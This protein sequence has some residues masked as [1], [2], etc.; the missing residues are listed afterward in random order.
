M[1]GSRKSPHNMPM[2]TDAASRPPLIAKALF[3][4]GCPFADQIESHSDPLEI[5]ITTELWRWAFLPLKE[6]KDVTA[7][8]SELCANLEFYLCGA[9]HL[10]EFTRSRG[11]WCDGVI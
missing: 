9:F 10:I 6:R 8:G 2:Q 11:I 4:K 7:I 3:R 5:A 1:R